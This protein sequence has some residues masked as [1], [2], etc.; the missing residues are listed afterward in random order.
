MLK[1]S[2]ILVEKYYLTF[3]TEVDYIILRIDGALLI[4]LKI[5]DSSRIH[6][7]F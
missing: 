4:K 5:A 3:L 1:V 7:N 6:I 2:V